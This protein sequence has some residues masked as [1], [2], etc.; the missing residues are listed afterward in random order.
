MHDLRAYTARAETALQDGDF[1]AFLEAREDLLQ[2]YGLSVAREHLAI[3]G[4]I[5]QM[6]TSALANAKRLNELYPQLRHELYGLSDERAPR[7]VA[8]VF[9]YTA[10]RATNI[11]IRG[12]LYKMACRLV[13]TKLAADAFGRRHVCAHYPLGEPH[14]TEFSVYNRHQF[15]NRMAAGWA[16][17]G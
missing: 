6:I 12:R 14:P 15:S 16:S 11:N 10:A 2:L 1:S 7:L 5:D 4:I 17:A 9:A 3:L 8:E 13:D